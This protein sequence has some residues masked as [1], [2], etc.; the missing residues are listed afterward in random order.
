MALLLTCSPDDP[1][2]ISSR[3]RK[4]SLHSG[5]FRALHLM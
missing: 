5:P 1:T 2:S 3:P 4:F